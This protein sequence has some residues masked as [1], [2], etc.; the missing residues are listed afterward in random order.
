MGY[1]DLT[2][3]EELR[4]DPTFT[5]ALGKRIGLE[6]EPTENRYIKKRFFAN[7]TEV[8]RPNTNQK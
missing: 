7:R 3:H 1:E 6:N 8:W 4:H 2:D 5:L